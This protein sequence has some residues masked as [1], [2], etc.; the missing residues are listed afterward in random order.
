M[1]ISND[2]K[3]CFDDVMIVPTRSE[4]ASRS[5]VDLVREFNFPHQ[6]HW[7][8]IPIIA[9][10]MLTGNFKIADEL[11]KFEMST[12][13]AKHHNKE[14]KNKCSLDL[15]KIEELL[16]S[17]W[18]TIGM[19]EDELN[20]LI[21][22]KKYLYDQ[23]EILDRSLL[24]ICIDIA[25]GYSQKF[26]DFVSKV[27][28]EFQYNVIMAGNVCTPEMTQELILHG[29]DIVKIGISPGGACSTVYKTGVGYPQISAA[30][31]CSYVAH[32]L[33]AFICLD[34]GIKCPG[35]VA[36]AFGANADFVMVGSILG[37]SDE[38][39]GI[40]IEKY[41]LEGYN[42]IYNSVQDKYIIEPHYVLKKYKE[43]YGM[44]SRKAME[45][46]GEGMKEYRTSEGVETFLPYTGPIENTIQDILGGLRSAC[47]YIGAKQIKNMGKCC[48]FIRVNNQH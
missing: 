15:H 47:T 21:S 29:A 36:K 22:F 37:G 32:G 43:W 39:D 31:E 46:H 28:K 33:N 45:N 20:E 27:R 35:D 13:I 19:K 38:S 48:K 11:Q 26:A 7:K 44:S 3:L 41:E 4:L 5:E 40:C 1:I 17:S 10:N 24:K 25:N 14:W 2:I 12:A 23:Y 34:G 16:K 6:G 18:Y 9:A 30:L 8:G 42:S